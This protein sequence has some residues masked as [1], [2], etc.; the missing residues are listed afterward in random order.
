VQIE[1]G[2][3]EV[4]TP[5]FVRAARRLNLK[6]D[7]WTVNEREDMTRLIALP[8]DGSSPTTRTAC[9]R[10]AGSNAPSSGTGAGTTPPR[11]GVQWNAQCFRPAIAS[12]WPRCCSTYASGSTANPV[13]A[14]ADDVDNA[15]G[16][17]DPTSS[18][19]QSST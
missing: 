12:A 5:R 6:I 10:C 19:P 14:D 1:L 8:V 11:G 18:E 17:S 2:N 3:L 15:L 9:S 13:C 16:D 4:L 7:V